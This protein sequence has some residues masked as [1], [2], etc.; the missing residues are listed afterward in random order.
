MSE[1]NFEAKLYSV[2]KSKDGMIVA[3]VVQPHDTADLITLDIG[4]HLMI[5]WSGIADHDARLPSAEDVKGILAPEPHLEPPKK[6]KTPFHELPLCKQAVLRC[7]DAEFKAYLVWA[8]R[9]GNR[10]VE[11]YVRWYCE[12]KSR[13]ELDDPANTAA[14]DTWGR[15]NDDF[16]SWK[17]TAQYKDVLR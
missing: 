16:E 13:A 15:L 4:A 3:F 11:E 10:P 14:R 8:H 12:V 9:I 1:G 6:P 5:G 7:K 17:L 2:R